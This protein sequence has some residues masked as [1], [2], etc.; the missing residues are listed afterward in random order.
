[1]FSFWFPFGEF[2]FVP[3]LGRERVLEGEVMPQWPQ[4]PWRSYGLAAWL[5]A[6]TMLNANMNEPSC[7]SEV[8]P[9][10]VFP[11]PT[12]ALLFFLCASWKTGF[13]TQ[14]HLRLAPKRKAQRKAQRAGD[15]KTPPFSP[16]LLSEKDREQSIPAFCF[17]PSLQPRTGT[18]RGTLFSR[19]MRCGR[20]AN[21][22][23]MPTPQ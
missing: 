3:A 11:L 5:G 16:S 20:L 2:G 10:C 6:G 14:R 1:M 22:T 18:G 19:F 15:V 21:P 17:R 7:G 12:W 8:H 4:L 23:S 13:F 9:N